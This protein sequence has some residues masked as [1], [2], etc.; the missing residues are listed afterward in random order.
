MTDVNMNNQT[1][2]IDSDGFLTDFSQW[3][4]Q[5]ACD[6]AHKEGVSRECPLDDGRMDIIKYMRS[7]YEKFEAFPILRAVCKNVGQEKTC[8][9]DRFPDPITAWKI[10]GLPKPTPEVYAKISTLA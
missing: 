10:A 2:S 7:Y 3:T 6:L 8:H 4:E 5:V 9:Y 1:I